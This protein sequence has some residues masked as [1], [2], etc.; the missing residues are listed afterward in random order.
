[1]G[2]TLSVYFVG[3]FRR[4]QPVAGGIHTDRV[5]VWN[6]Q[7]LKLSRYLFLMTDMKLLLYCLKIRKK[8]AIATHCSRLGIVFLN[9]FFYYYRIF[10]VVYDV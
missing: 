8:I 10:C 4:A 9:I 1:M 6:K 2:F 5:Y 7:L 3:P